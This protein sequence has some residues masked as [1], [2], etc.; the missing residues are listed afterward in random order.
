MICLLT[1]PLTELISCENIFINFKLTSF[2]ESQ[3]ILPLKGSLSVHLYP[4]TMLRILTGNATS[5]P[6][7]CI[8]P[9]CLSVVN[10]ASVVNRNVGHLFVVLLSKRPK[11][12]VNDSRVDVAGLSVSLE[13]HLVQTI[14]DQL[15]RPN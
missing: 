15:H 7:V 9:V 8:T 4:N 3:F 10:T 5:K 11:V 13:H 1:R 2:M 6:C 14:L 12:E